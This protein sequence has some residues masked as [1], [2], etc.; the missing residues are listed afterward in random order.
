MTN[1]LL[2]HDVTRQDVESFLQRPS[3]NVLIIGAQGSGKATLAQHI[4]A[5][6]LSTDT[7]KLSTY[8]HYIVVRPTKKSISIDEVRRLHDFVRLKTAGTN[9]IRRAI[10]IEDA[11]TLTVEAQNAFLKLLEEPPADTLIVMTAE[12]HDALLPTILSRV[13]KIA[14]KTPTQSAASEHFARLGHDTV[15]VT[16]NYFI[17]RGQAGL[18]TR[19]LDSKEGDESLQQI[20][21]AKQFLQ[22]TP[23]DRLVMSDKIIKDKTDLAQFLWALQ[24]VA[25]T[26]LKQS[27]QKNLSKQV[28]HWKQS[29]KAIVHAQDSLQSNPQAKLLL[30]NLSLQC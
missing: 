12:G 29:L 24:R 19:L 16:K 25:D 23:F 22:A 27:A 2:L 6:A 8:P 28:A 17:S 1:E 30:A 11:H 3:H 5:S 9:A 18:M 4:V 7:V 15:H 21:L 14:L 20:A 10:I 26:A 13:P